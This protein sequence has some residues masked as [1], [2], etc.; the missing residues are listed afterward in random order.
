MTSLI[1]QNL[2]GC[3]FVEPLHEGQSCT[4]YRCLQIDTN[5]DVAVKIL[6]KPISPHSSKRL[7]NESRLLMRLQ[8]PN[9]PS[10]FDF[11]ISEE[12]VPYT[13]MGL[14]SGTPLN[15]IVQS[16]GP[17]SSHRF[18][19]VFSSMCNAMAYCHDQEIVHK[20]LR[21]SHFLLSKDEA[22]EELPLIFDFAIAEFFGKGVPRDDSQVGEVVGTPAY[23]SPEQAMAQSVD[24]RSDIYSMGCSMFFALSGEPP[25]K[26]ISMIDS[27]QMHMA[28]QPPIDKLPDEFRALVSKALAK[29]PEHRYRSMKEFASAINA[30][31]TAREAAPVKK[32]RWL[33]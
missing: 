29:S 27:M 10:V 7:L 14:Y 12:M 20:N 33:F 15:E 6:N 31:A 5:R 16:E 24:A 2:H 4:V 23:M 3:K 17:L 1:N 21:P 13:I 26:G 28:Q 25:F 18:R 9:F 22:G 19:S 32:K 8:L 30:G 11:G